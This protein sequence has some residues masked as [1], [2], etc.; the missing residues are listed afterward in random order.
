MLID[1]LDNRGLANEARATQQSRDS[2]GHA[3]A[4]AIKHDDPLV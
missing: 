4:L 2:D 3:A 1:R